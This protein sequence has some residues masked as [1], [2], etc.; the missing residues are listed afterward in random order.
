MAYDEKLCNEKHLNI[1]K[2]LDEH[3]D[4]LDGHSKRLDT[5]EVENGSLKTEMKNVCLKIESL[6]NTIKWGLGIFVTI[7]LFILSK[8]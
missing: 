3:K 2:I 6:I 7:V 4:R 8:K 5:L 1:E